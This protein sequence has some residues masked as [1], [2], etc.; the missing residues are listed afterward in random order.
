[1]THDTRH[2]ACDTWYVTCGEGSRFSQNFCSLALTVWDYGCF[3]DLEE[4]DDS[5]NEWITKVFVE[6][7]WLQQVC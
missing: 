5:H 2:M 1:M 7:P 4:K 6:Q 3:E